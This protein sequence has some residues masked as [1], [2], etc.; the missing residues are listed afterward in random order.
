MFYKF[1]FFYQFGRKIVIM[2][3][4]NQTWNILGDFFRKKGFVHHQIDS[5][6][7][8][9]NVDIPRI[10]TE[11]ADIVISQ[12]EGHKYTVKF[13]DVYIPP[14]TVSEDDRTLRN[15]FPAEVRY[16]SLTY[17]SPI[18]VDITEIS[19]EVGN[20]TEVTKH[21]RVFIGRTP[22][23]LRSD[24]CNLRD[25]TPE[26]RVRKGECE[27]D[28]GG[29]FIIKG[30][31]RV[32]V[33]QLRGVYNQPIVLVQKPNEKFKYICEIR[34]MS[35]ETGHSVLLQAKIGVD[36]R[37][38][39]FSLPYIKELIPVGIVFKAL[40][41]NEEQIIDFIGM[42]GEQ[43]EKYLRLIT[44]DCFYIED[45]EHALRVIGQHAIH[46]IKEDARQSYAWQVVESE[47][48][49]HL[50]V[51]SSVKEKAYFLGYMIKKLLSTHIGLRMDDDR[52]N[53][54]NKRVEMAGVLCSDLFRTLFKRYTKTIS[55]QL[56]KKKQRP[57]AM[58]IISRLTTI[59]IG[60]QHCFSTGNW[61]VQKN[62][63]FRTGVSQ[64]LSRL[65]YGATLSH[66]RRIVIPIG[67][68]GK[69]AKIRQIHSSQIM[70]L[71]PAETPE[72]QSIG[73]VL[74][75]SL[76]TTISHRISTIL[77]K[78]IL[79]GSEHLVSLED[80]E[81][82][83]EQTKVFLNGTMLG[84]VEDPD[85]F[86]DEVKL[87][88]EHG[89]IS[90]EI[91]VS[92]DAIDEE[93]KIFSDE[94]RLLRPLF[95]VKDGKLDI[96]PEDGT[97]WD[98]LVNRQLIRY[99]DN[100]EIEGCTIAM[101]Q[102][103]LPKYHNDYCE[104]SPSMM[105]G[106]MASIIP[107]P[108]HSQSPRNCYQCLDPNELVAMADGTRKKI[109]DI[110]VGDLVVTV[111]PVTYNQSI[112]T[113]VNQYVRPTEKTISTFITE[114]GRYITCTND[115]PVL[116]SSGWKEA[117][118]AHDIGI[119]PQQ[120]IYTADDID[121][122]IILPKTIVKDKHILT[123]SQMGLY[124]VKAEYIPTLARIVGF[125]LADGSAEIYR[126]YPQIQMTFG[127][128]KGCESFQKDVEFL[129]F[130]RNAV[131]AEGYG[132]AKQV[133]YNNAFASLIIGL[134]G[135]YIGKRS[136]QE[137][138]PLPQWIINSSKAV[139][140]E[141]LA[142]FQGGDGCKFRYNILPG[143]NNGNFILNSTSQTIL[144]ENVD[145]LV[146][147]MEQIKN[148]FNEFGILC[149]GPT[150]RSSKNARMKTVHIY[151]HNTKQN[152]VNYFERIGWRYDHYKYSESL[153]VYEYL[154]KCLYSL[155]Q[156]QTKNLHI[157]LLNK[158]NISNTQIGNIVNKKTS[159]VSDILKS[160]RNKTKCRLPNGYITYTEW[161]KN[162]VISDNILFVKIE[163]YVEQANGYIADISVES[164][165]HS[166]IAGDSFCV[167]NSSMGKQAI[168]MFALS[169]QVR[170]DTIVHV[171]DYPQRPLVSTIP[172]QFMGFNDMPSGINVI[173]AIACYTGL[174]SV[175]PLPHS[176][177]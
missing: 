6:N 153:P 103:D 108:D 77:V 31:E 110:M 21:K 86:V 54:V 34:S 145:S 175:K 26:E 38:I 144:L 159:Q 72:G 35:R 155:K 121:I 22:I 98:D 14:P 158:N 50:G 162:T 32:L 36:D 30:N 40:G 130:R 42:K 69:N 89:L 81:G 85:A 148:I 113:V 173:V 11:E 15:I 160:I 29:Y 65:T 171:L 92:Y 154:R 39:V 152:L 132:R 122:D 146:R 74:N 163:K 76:T 82:P 57:D 75:M 27:W 33:G 63:Y 168:G 140:R 1:D 17:N 107:F 118:Q 2:I 136:T 45:K 49:P 58:S 78:E 96:K 3:S 80:F 156:I 120:E 114:S 115:H 125:L 62:T 135:N 87:F 43:V 93:V 164:S 150:I 106:V 88:R 165:N 177:M 119:I 56:E 161:V 16:R 101:D 102:T 133:V 48:L 44:R 71:C 61:G 13:G 84:M 10:V 18:Y 131:F 170:T 83:N 129:G 111:D 157:E 172:S 95:V 126:N 137:H 9:I 66:L 53:Y 25:C 138:P 4:E 52:D 169:H 112:T 59:T 94:G 166:F 24:R 117:T 143:R 51:T 167:H 55:Q 37:T 60:L 147:F 47:L 99:V 73:I 79:E 64:V 90:Q 127:S 97:D 7:Q 142:G 5:F 174:T 139:K 68:E 123:L 151:F 20:P 8:Y 67:K 134:I 19:E 41:Y 104:I 109:A 100:N 70:Y 91:S 28:Q 105:L 149:S 128:D 116:T 12:S 124:P 176:N 141:F 46:I 23:M